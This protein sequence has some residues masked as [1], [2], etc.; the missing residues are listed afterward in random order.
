[1]LSNLP[2]HGDNHAARSLLSHFPAITEFGRLLRQALLKRT[3]TEVLAVEPEL[4]RELRQAAA[5]EG[6]IERMNREHQIRMQYLIH[7]GV[8]PEERHEYLRLLE[9]SSEHGGLSP[10]DA[11]SLAHARHSYSVRQRNG[12][13]TDSFVGVSIPPASS[14]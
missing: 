7:F 3:A 4:Q 9:E 13:S 10:Q 11:A 6:Q 1:M 14:V 5:V 2:E 12:S 8:T